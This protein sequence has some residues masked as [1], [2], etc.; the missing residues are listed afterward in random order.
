MPHSELDAANEE[1]RD[2][3]ATALA[4][5]LAPTSIRST[6]N[7]SNPFLATHPSLDP[8][9][10]QFNAKTWT[11]ALR[12]AFAQDSE[13]YPQHPMGVSWRDLGVH[14]FGSDID[15]QKDCLNVLWRGF[16]RVREW[17]SRRKQ[18]L[19]ILRNFDGLVQSG[20]MLLVLGRPGSGVTTLLKTIAGQTHGLNLDQNTRFN[21]QGIPWDVMHSRFRGEVIYQAEMD[22]HFSQLTVGQTLSFAALARTPRNRLH[23]IS[24]KLY[25]QHMRDVVM[26]VFGISHTINSKLGNNYVR[27]ISGGE[28]K[29]VSIA[30]VTL[31]RS[32]IQC[33][34]NST[35]GL[36]SATALEFAKT[37]KLSTQL[38]GTTAIVSIY[39]ASQSAYD[40]FHKVTVLYEGRQI[41]FGH[42][43]AAKKYFT[44]LGYHCPDRETTADFLTSLT[45]PLERVVEP[46]FESKVPRTPVEFAEVWKK[47]A[48]R[49]QVLREI[50]TFEEA[51]PMQGHQLGQLK[52]ARK[53][54]QAS[55]TLD[56]RNK[57]PYTLSIPMQINLCIIRGF[58]C[59]RGDK[60]FFAVTI[61]ANFVVSLALGSIYYNLSP[62]ADTLNSKCVLLY[63]ALLFN[64]LTSV[65]E[66]F[67]LYAKQPIIEKQSRYALCHP[68]A[69]AISSIICDLPSKIL[70]TIVFSI[71]M[72]FL[73]NLRQEVSSFFIYLLFSF[74]CTLSV[75]MILRSIGQI[76]RTIQ[77]ALAP[78]TVFILASVLYVGF[79]LPARNMQ[80]WLRWINY[81]DPIAYAYESLVANEFSGR[82]F[83]CTQFIPRGSLYVNSTAF[84]RTCSVAGALPGDD[85]IDGDVY[86][87]ASF[88]YYRSHI[89][90]NFGILIA[91]IIFFALVYISVAEYL[92][93]S[94]SRGEILVFRR[95][96]ARKSTSSMRRRQDEESTGASD[97]RARSLHTEANDASHAASEQDVVIQKPNSVFHWSNITYDITIKDKP[98]RIL[99]NVD[100]WVKPGALTALMGATGAGKT[101]LLDVLAD[102]VTMGVITGDILVDGYPRR[103]A[104]HRQTG[105]VQQEDLHLQTSTV[106]EALRFSAAL[107]QPSEVSTAQKNLY[108]EEVIGL[109]NMEAYAD[110]VI[111]VPG[112]GLNVEQR[113]RLTIGVE[114]AAKP[115]LLIFLDEP[116]SGLDSQTAWSIASLI[117]KLSDNG[118]AVL[119]TIH[120][121]SAMLFQKF[122][123]LL[124]LG[125]GGKTVYFGDIGENSRI[126]TSY[127][128]RHGA[129]LCDTSE[130]PAEWMLRVIGAF[131]GGHGHQNWA[132]IWRNS[133]E[134][135]AVRKELSEL[136][137]VAVTNSRPDQNEAPEEPVSYYATPF[138]HQF[139]S[140]TKR[141]FEHYWRIP[142]YIY[143]KLTL[144]GG[145]SLFIGVSFYRSELTMSGLQQQMFSIF[146]LLVIFAFLAYQ[147]MPQ[148]IVLR[149]QY[150]ER[151]RDSHSYSW[152]VFILSN[153]VVELPWNLLA[154][155]LVI[156]PFY[157]LVGMN[158]NA[159]PTDSVNER[160]MFMFLLTWSF[161]IFESTFTD[162]AVAGAGTAE[163]GA[164]I[165]L[166][167][168]ALSLLSCGV[169]VPYTALPRPWIAMYKVSP[170]TYI[171]SAM[172]STGI[173]NHEVKCVD[174]ELLRFQPGSAQNCGEYM[175]PF[176]QIAGGA[177]YNPS[178]TSLCMYCPLVDTNVFLSSFGALYD[179]RW[180]NLG[181]VW[182]YIVFNIFA[183]LFLYWAAR[184]PKKIAWTGFLPEY[185][186]RGSLKRWISPPG[187]TVRG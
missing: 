136:V 141:A 91:Y 35:R 19:Q 38:D 33:W 55:F 10:P 26:A 15:C 66:V 139:L 184:V 44:D 162:M 110:A 144:C 18:R 94:P 112:E 83:Q 152:Y 119:C 95:K 31:N 111:G 98:R 69:E 172:L 36:D 61:L 12:Y 108:V 73:A 58:Q 116:T 3:Q 59:L 142:S 178:D 57:S 27:G 101:T 185:F 164:A 131:P 75:S 65:L 175:A 146:M 16:M 133:Q 102:R 70:S 11:K 54:Q 167:L 86:I 60:C 90:R 114:L 87:N 171:V 47:S 113:K 150:E 82:Q 160:S 129:E 137:S 42:K 1:I 174:L 79:V 6:P 9:S 74:T 181:L 145:T 64:C 25:A 165:A 37:L 151:E 88:E 80:G 153:V 97:S 40:A 62:T 21:Y 182:A 147:T 104:F 120:Q 20:E 148:F 43:D 149:Q 30:E 124:L 132:D 156:P 143:A 77:Q 2:E 128:E 127:F 176:T 105:Y 29:R 179:E 46:G 52:A 96:G 138:H 126:V 134:Y 107:R 89:W 72:Y 109:L 130:N 117:R 123:R 17:L 45:N 56:R 169:M 67:S 84:Q 187:S 125:S 154:S 23:G 8:N 48:A 122:D 140:C 41:Y 78:A 24:R 28:R 163:V 13:K 186:K 121:P 76:S 34:D 32:A 157:Y 5:I 51:Y 100:G 93:L 183:A 118:Q 53:T 50:R 49:A 115:D 68:F 135:A 177:V 22:I 7:D 158:K 81:L 85:F 14:G 63:F 39:Q 159:I 166:L 180:R 4:K 103:K 99:D 168:F 106:R 170:F 173:A 161:I 71:P 92:S 155:L